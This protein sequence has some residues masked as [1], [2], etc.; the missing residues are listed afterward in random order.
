M[1]LRGLGYSVA[2]APP[3]KVYSISDCL[4]KPFSGNF[5]ADA[6]LLRC[7]IDRR[8]NRAELHPHHT[9]I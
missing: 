9:Q 6:S 8:A 5:P 4:R 7:M 2:P 3:L 1:Y